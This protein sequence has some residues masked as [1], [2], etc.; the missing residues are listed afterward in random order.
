MRPGVYALGFFVWWAGL[1]S[2]QH[3]RGAR[4]TAERAHK[5]PSLPKEKDPPRDSMS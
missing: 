5:V 4:V 1:D 2:H 3:S